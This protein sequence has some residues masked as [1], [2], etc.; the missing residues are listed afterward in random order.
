L[1][2][3]FHKRDFTK[4]EFETSA[5]YEARMA[6]MEGTLAG[7]RELIVCQYLDDNEDVRFTYDAE[8]QAFSTSFDQRLRA[9][10]DWKKTGSYVSK[11]R[12]GARATVTSYF[13]IDYFIDMAASTISPS[14]D[15]IKGGYSSVSFTVPVPLAE[16]P[17]V[18]ADGYLVILG[19][20]ASPFYKRTQTTGS[21]T[22]DDPSDVTQVE[23]TATIRPRAFYIVMPGGKIIWQCELSRR[24]GDAAS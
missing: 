11:T 6:G 20:L 8:K 12:M 2:G 10:I 16:A 21:P 24:G 1:D 22:L 15:C 9:E 19:R 5:A 3:F 7:D 18:K 14:A 23:M 17:A 13:G 4:G